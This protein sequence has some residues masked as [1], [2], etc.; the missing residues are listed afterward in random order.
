M[1]A[2]IVPSVEFSVIPPPE[3]ESEGEITAAVISPA[4]EI[5]TVVISQ[6]DKLANAWRRAESANTDS[7]IRRGEL[8]QRYLSREL[9]DMT[10]I[11]RR[12]VRG[13]LI[14]AAVARLAYEGYDIN[15]TRLLKIHAAA[16]LLGQDTAR[17]VSPS[18][19]VK[20]APLLEHQADCE[21]YDLTH[22]EAAM[23]LWHRVVYDRLSCRAV[24][25]QVGKILGV[26]DRPATKRRR[27]TDASELG[28]KATLQDVSDFLDNLSCEMFS[29]MMTLCRNYDQTTADQT[30]AAA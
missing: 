29:Y 9:T 4:T 3:I 6:L 1:L 12:T 17:T 27:I 13:E 20:F 24:Q 23:D 28:K 16:V 19:L 25:E 5:T 10:G 26:T 21:E 15:A 22:A 14:A 11:K 18:V 8:L 2:T 7:A 30:A